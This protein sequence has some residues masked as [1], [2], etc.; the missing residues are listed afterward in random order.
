MITSTLDG[1][2]I[3]KLSD[4]ELRLELRR[5]ITE[6]ARLEGPAK[7]FHE[8]VRSVDYSEGQLG[9]VVTVYTCRECGFSWRD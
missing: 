6:A 2:K 1:R 7:C 9:I 8:D 3:D 4:T 5:M